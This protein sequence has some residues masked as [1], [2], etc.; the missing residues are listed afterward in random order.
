MN[1]YS[2]YPVNESAT[3]AY[4]AATGQTRLLIAPMAF[5]GPR[6]NWNAKSAAPGSHSVTIDVLSDSFI[7]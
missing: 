6:D 3:T 5:P 4:P 7:S 2:H 1:H